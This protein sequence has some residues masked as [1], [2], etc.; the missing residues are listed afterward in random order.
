MQLVKAANIFIQQMKNTRATPGLKSR[1]PA[2][3]YSKR[4][5]AKIKLE[6]QLGFISAWSFAVSHG[7]ILSQGAGAGLGR[8]DSIGDSDLRLHLNF[9][10]PILT[11]I[12]SPHCGLCRTVHTL[13]A[14]LPQSHQHREDTMGGSN[15]VAGTG[16]PSSWRALEPP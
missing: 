1:D 16:D 13:A 3:M 4:G 2:E 5:T 6:L 11:H 9:L 10:P 12:I 15:P 8:G 7:I 14:N